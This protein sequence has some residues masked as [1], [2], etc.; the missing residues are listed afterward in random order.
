MPIVVASLFVWKPQSALQGQASTT[1]SRDLPSIGAGLANLTVDDPR[2]DG[3]DTEV[4]SRAAEKQLEELAGILRHPE[5]LESSQVGS[6]VTDQFLCDS[7]VPQ[8]VRPV[9][10]DPAIQVF[11]AKE[12]ERGAEHYRGRGGM[13]GALQKLLQPYRKASDIHTAFKLFQVEMGEGFVTTRQYFSLSG[14]TAAG[15]REQNATWKMRWIQPSDGG[16]PLVAHIEVED[17]EHVIARSLSQTLFA[18]CTEAVLGHNACFSPQLMHGLNHWMPRIQMLLGLEA[19]GHQGVAVGDVNGDSLEDVYLCQTGGL[20]NRLFIQN[21]DGTATDV[22]KVAG[23]DFVDRTRSALMID[24]DNDGDQ[25]L[26]LT[27]RS[28]V[29]FMANDGLGHFRAQ[30]L[31][32]MV[33]DITSVAAADYD[34]DGDLDLYLCAYFPSREDISVLGTPLPYHDA[35]NGGRNVLLRNENNWQF[36]DMTN[37]VGLDHNNTRWSYATSWEDYDN[38][39]DQDLYVAN[40]FG[41][42]N[43]YRN[44]DGHFLDV[45]GQAGVEDISSGMGVTWGDYDRDGQM[46]LYVSNMFSAA[47]S[48][49]T[50][51]R[52]FKRDASRQTKAQFQRHARGN[53]LFENSGKGTFRDVSVDA[54]VTMGRMAWGSLFFD[55]NN[56]GW[57]DLV[58]LNGLVTNE[59]AEDL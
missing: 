12:P 21:A 14:R 50:Y 35:N 15:S 27:P 58:V 55:L 13:I 54:G 48:R 28:G 17:Y 2:E 49:I 1:G 7:L 22:S 46:D 29:L 31:V 42:N 25:D 45:A 10:R 59:K 57:D 34:Q 30:T 40:D 24:M 5:K 36:T 18:D 56:D 44:D 6:L 37:L 39:G 43:L 47:G 51:Q 4:F 9:F 26:V 19:A 53:S 32:P 23:V 41:R 52:Q 33:S 38:D 20:P 11:R 16:A 8:E 3:W